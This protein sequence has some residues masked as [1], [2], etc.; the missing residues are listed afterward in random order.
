V[1]KEYIK[2]FKNSNDKNKKK[3]NEQSYYNWQIIKVK[4]N[5]I[6]TLYLIM[7]AFVYNWSNKDPI[8]VTDWAINLSISREE[9]II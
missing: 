2:S 9:S 7:I 3:F 8:I 1:K 5:K 6:V 4:V